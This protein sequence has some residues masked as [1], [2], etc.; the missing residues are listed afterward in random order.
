MSFAGQV[1]ARQLRGSWVTGVA[2]R[3]DPNNK[4]RQE[5][6]PLLNRSR[7]ALL[8]IAA[9]VMLAAGATFLSAHNGQHHFTN[10]GSEGECSYLCSVLGHGYSYTGNCC[11]CN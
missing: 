4:R 9:G 3:R 2:N 7:K 1:Q 8:A 6:R 10:V 11:D 5:M